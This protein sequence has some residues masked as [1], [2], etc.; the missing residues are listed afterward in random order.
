M[1]FNNAVSGIIHMLYHIC[2]IG[3]LCNESTQFSILYI[4]FFKTWFDAQDLIQF[5][6][7]NFLCTF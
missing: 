7:R 2:T 4:Q 1:I 6:V 3:I 5:L